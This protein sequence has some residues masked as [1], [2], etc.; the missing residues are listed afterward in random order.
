MNIFLRGTRVVLGD[1]GSMP[2]DG[3]GMPLPSISLL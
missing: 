3:G 2:E 1:G